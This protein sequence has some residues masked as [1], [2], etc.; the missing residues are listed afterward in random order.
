MGMAWLQTQVT[1]SLPVSPSRRKHGHSVELELLDVHSKAT[2]C[3]STGVQREAVYSTH[4]T[5]VAAD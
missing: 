4:A 5:H 3:F 2:A 1:A